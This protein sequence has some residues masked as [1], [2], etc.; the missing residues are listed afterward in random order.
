MKHA[1]L[2]IAH[3]NPEILYAQLEILDSFDVDFYY[4]LDTK[5]QIDKDK[6][7]SYAT[8]SRIFYIKPQ[9]IRW[10]HYSQIECE[11]RLLEA[12][13][14]SKENYNYY[15]LLSGVDMPLKSYKSIDDFF[16]QNRGKEFIHF[17]G[18]YVDED[19]RERLSLYHLSPSRSHWQRKI[20]GFFV[21]LQRIIKIDRLKK[22]GWKVQKGAN[23]FSIT[24]DLAKNIIKNRKIIERHFRYSFCG[25]EVFLQ[26]FVFNSEFCSQLYS[27]KFDNDYHACM[28]LIDWK[29]GNPYVFDIEDFDELI[30]SDY[31][32]ARKFDYE[33]K[34]EIINKLRQYLR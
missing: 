7:E 3:N 26:T 33:K 31:M 15:H 34:P 17:D 29:R 28:R 1:F 23:W 11:L 14:H 10:G 6:L 27:D 24:G 16:S 22:S 12:A 20:N 8:K 25:D 32:F 18:K 5:M 4:H 21:I 13:V 19:I 9:K 2:I 30:N